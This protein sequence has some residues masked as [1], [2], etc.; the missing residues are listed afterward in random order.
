MWLSSITRLNTLPD[1]R[2]FLEEVYR[3]LAPD[4]IIVVGVPNFASFMSQLIPRALGGITAGPASMALYAADPAQDAAPRK[5]LH[6]PLND[7][8]TVHHHPNRVKDLALQLASRTAN[9]DGR[10]D[11]MLAVAGKCTD[12][13]T[14]G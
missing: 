8:R 9:G 7:R 6:G 11:S 2:A 5:L 13:D 10:G 3:I 14:A 1:P 12:D 4:G